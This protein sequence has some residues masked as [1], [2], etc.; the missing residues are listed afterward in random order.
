MK[1]TLLISALLLVTCVA[2]AQDQ[3]LGAVARQ[4]RAQKKPSAKKVFTNDDIATARSP[5]SAPAETAAQPAADAKAADAKPK[6]PAAEDK[7]KA[8][9][10]MQAKVNSLKSEI[11][12]LQRELDV[13]D[14]EFKLQ[15]ASYYADAGNSLRDPKK[16]ADEQRNK[17]A[18]LDGKK[19]AIDDAKAKLADTLE[20]ARKADIKVNE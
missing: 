12:A 7:A 3:S 11:A 1:R 20:Q 17:Q 15:V 16:W 18:E 10:A 6:A 2:V 5:D 8:A 9:A 19:K 4:Q 14:R 13:A